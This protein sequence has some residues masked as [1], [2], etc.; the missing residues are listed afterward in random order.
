MIAVT[1]LTSCKDDE[2]IPSPRVFMEAPFENQVISSVDTVLVK[3]RITHDVGI[4]WVEV[5]LL[6]D[7]FSPVSNKERY[8]LTG[9]DLN[10]EAV[11]IID[12]PL[13]NAGFYYVAVRASDGDKIGSGFSKVQ[14][15]AI[16]RQLDQIL[17]GTRTTFDLGVWG[18]EGNA[19]WETVLT[20][21]IDCKGMALNFRDDI[22]AIAGGEV[23]NL[24]FHEMGE[25]GVIQSVQGF[26]L[27]SQ[28]FFLGLEYSQMNEQF[29]A[30]LRTPR[31]EVRNKFASP[32]VSFDLIFNHLP[33]AVFATA[34]F[35]YT[36]ESPISQPNQLLI[37]YSK[38]GLRMVVLEL[39][40]PLRGLFEGNDFEIYIWENHPDGLKLRRVN[41]NSQLISDLF[42]RPGE[43]LKSAV[44]LD[45]GVF[46]FLS[47]QGLYR[48]SANTG[49]TI[50]LNNGIEGEA[51]FYDDL[52]QQYYI[53]NGNVLRILASNGVQIDMHTFPSE[54]FWVGFDYNR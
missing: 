16:A 37:Q 53:G 17:V 3:A 43:V 50:V 29:M 12:Q 32:E 4:E 42:Q 5:E 23:G 6:R 30:L 27:S 38:A 47:N 20:K 46:A 18:K 40:G 21:A 49:S 41:Y 9:V 28:P 44:Q 48:Y 15:N 14:L 39:G 1:F 26:G 24:D 52:N 10:F 22:L 13:L 2:D 34:G 45:K 51:L 8:N 33:S 7:D 11:M 54:V 25:Y 36:V 35:Y 19:G 31:M